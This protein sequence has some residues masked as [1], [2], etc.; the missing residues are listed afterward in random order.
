[1]NVSDILERAADLFGGTDPY[2]ACPFCQ[3][4]NFDTPGLL[5]HLFSGCD[6]KTRPHSDA[7][8]VAGLRKAAAK[9]RES[10]Q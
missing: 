8:I 1:M 2:V 5:S 7:D 4:D 9:A 3:Q 6:G 10:G